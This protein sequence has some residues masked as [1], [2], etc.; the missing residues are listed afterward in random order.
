MT[1]ECWV[2]LLQSFAINPTFV[3]L[4]DDNNGGWMSSATFGKGNR[5]LENFIVSFKIGNWGGSETA[6]YFSY[7][8]SQ[9]QIV[10]MI[11]GKQMAYFKQS[12]PALLSHGPTSRHHPFIP[13]LQILAD[14][15]KE[16]ETVRRNL[17]KRVRAC[18]AKTECSAMAN[19]EAWKVA[20]DPL[21]HSRTL[22]NLTDRLEALCRALEH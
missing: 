11:C 19:A 12:L 5:Q 1:R 3:E 22:Y 2:E 20:Y 15:H 14:C 10:M 8:V 7:D 4:I 17:D 9:E 13:L 21:N 6:V 16:A 18:E